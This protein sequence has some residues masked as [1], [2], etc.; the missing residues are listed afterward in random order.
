[1]NPSEI[2]PGAEDHSGS[3]GDDGGIAI[4]PGAEDM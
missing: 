1:M 2:D 3:D 4:D